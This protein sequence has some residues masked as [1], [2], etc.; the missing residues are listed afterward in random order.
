MYIKYLFNFRNHPKTKICF[1][2]LFFSR[3]RNIYDALIELLASINISIYYSIYIV[4]YT[5][6]Q[7]KTLTAD[8]LQTN[9]APVLANLG[10]LL[11]TSVQCLTT[12]LA[13]FRFYRLVRLIVSGEQQMAWSHTRHR[14]PSCCSSSVGSKQ[15]LVQKWLVQQ[16]PSLDR[17]HQ[18]VNYPGPGYGNKLVSSRFSSTHP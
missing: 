7:Y 10:L 6:T 17:P 11:A 3:F 4:W 1:C 2:N 18:K 12:M 14:S 15:K 5:Q 8:Q 13:A 16:T 9:W